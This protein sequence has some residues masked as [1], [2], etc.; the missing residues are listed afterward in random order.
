MVTMGGESKSGD[1]FLVKDLPEGCMMAVIDGLGHGEEAA[2]AAKKGSDVIEKHAREGIIPLIRRCHDALRDTR[3]VVMSAAWVSAR[4]ESLVWAGVG[5]VEGL[6]LRSQPDVRPP[7]ESLLLRAGVVG[8]NL[9]AL[10]AGILPLMK[11]DVIILVTDGVRGD[12]RREVRVDQPPQQLATQ[13]LANYS[14]G[15]DDALVLVARYIG[16]GS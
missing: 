16:R 3:G 2:S 7:R 15:H 8:H 13:L 5:N 1:S 14:N 11:G 9:P 12:F 6:L 10:H 4:E